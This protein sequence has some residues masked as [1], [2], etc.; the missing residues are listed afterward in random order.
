M[1]TEAL[2]KPS[3]C[4]CADWSNSIEL[5]NGPIVREALRTGIDRYKFAKPFIFCPWC[6][7]LLP[8]TETVK[9]EP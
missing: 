8:P 3:G 2:V 6:G 1:E 7:T 5:V 9:S 4:Y